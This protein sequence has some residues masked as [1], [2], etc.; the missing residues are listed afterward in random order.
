MPFA[1]LSNRAAAVFRNHHF[2]FPHQQ[3]VIQ[4]FVVIGANGAR[5]H[6]L[7]RLARVAE[8]ISR[9]IG[10]VIAGNPK[11][12]QQVAQGLTWQVTRLIR[13]WLVLHVTLRSPD[14]FE[15]WYWS[16][17]TSGC[18]ISIQSGR[19]PANKT[20]GIAARRIVITCLRCSAHS[21]ARTEVA[22]K[23][24]RATLINKRDATV[25]AHGPNI[26]R[27]PDVA[28]F[29]QVFFCRGIHVIFSGWRPRLPGRQTRP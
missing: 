10:G 1:V 7:D 6:G 20:L 5:H 13:S 28:R 26:R 9:Q 12:R 17:A 22:I 3:P 29:V 27:Y 8:V 14:C 19:Y 24:C 4:Q 18:G 2:H 15:L 25:A 16:S 21:V 11:F 23:R